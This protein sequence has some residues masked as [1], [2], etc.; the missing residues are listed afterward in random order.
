[1]TDTTQDPATGETL[2]SNIV[3][4]TLRAGGGEVEVDTSKV[5]MAAYEAIFAAG[6]KHFID[7]A[8]DKIAKGITKL[9]AEEQVKAK[10]EL[11]S[12]A[13]KTVQSMYD[14]NLKTGRAKAKTSGAEQTEAMRLARALVK[15]TLRQNG[16]KVGAF[17]AKQHTDM[18]KEILADNPSLYAKAR[19]NLAQRAE[20]PV[21]GLDVKAMLGE[22]FGDETLKAKPKVPP[23]PKA[24]GDKAPL[25]AAQAGKVAPRQKPAG[26]TAH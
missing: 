5:E 11:V 13:L 19:E 22:R 25:S 17:S 15:D 1:M 12:Q 4:V 6:L 14:G 23:K 18:A 20:M 7:K 16:Y 26:A 10:A 3:K 9:S 8:G 21:K 24:K 2:P